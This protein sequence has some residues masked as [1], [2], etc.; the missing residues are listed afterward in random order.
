MI[1]L[2]FGPFAP[3]WLDFFL[4]LE[5]DILTLSAINNNLCNSMIHSKEIIFSL[6]KHQRGSLSCNSDFW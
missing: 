3:F 1:F 5:D 6:Q 4:M 2:L